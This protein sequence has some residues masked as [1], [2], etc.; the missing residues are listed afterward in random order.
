M[1]ITNLN[2]QKAKIKKNGYEDKYIFRFCK[3]K[4][5]FKEFE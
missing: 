4:I 3:K 1:V 5:Y 2:V